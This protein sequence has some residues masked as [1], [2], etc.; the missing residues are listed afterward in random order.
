MQNM[1]SLYELLVASSEEVSEGQHQQEVLPEVG[2]IKQCEL[3]IAKIL[4][5]NDLSDEDDESD[6]PVQFKSLMEISQDFTQ[7]TGIFKKL[8]K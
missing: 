1:S 3:E 7:P 5:L 8:R 6:D 4:E 2:T